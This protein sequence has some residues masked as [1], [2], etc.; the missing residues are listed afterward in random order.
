MEGYGS[1][2]DIFQIVGWNIMAVN[3]PLLPDIN[4]FEIFTSCDFCLSTRVY[5]IGM[6]LVSGHSDH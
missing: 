6:P 1:G 3:L 2:D 4:Y 5:E